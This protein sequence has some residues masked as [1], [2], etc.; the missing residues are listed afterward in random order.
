MGQ[1]KV[2]ALNGVNLSIDRG[3]FV[4]ILGTSGSGKST[5]LNMLAG[6]EKPSKGEIHV[7]GVALEKL[8]ERQLAKF[9]QL[10][11]GF[12]FQSYH[13][14][15]TLTAQENVALGLIFKGVPRKKRDAMAK[16]MLANVGLANRMKHKPSE[17]SGGQQQ[18]V[19]IARA[20]VDQPKI[21]FADEPTGNLDSRTSE[22]VMELIRGMAT[23]FKQTLVMVTHDEDTALHAN[24]IFHIIDGKLDRI[25][26]KT[27]EETHEITE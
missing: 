16:N 8:N 1:E 13:L 22:E 21:V 24:R 15:P 27:K 20:F 7:G 4:A 9:R 6:L 10:N 3:E 14:I 11:I 19:S 12:V 17:L 5:L 2:H 18:R 23:D 25:Q 26:T